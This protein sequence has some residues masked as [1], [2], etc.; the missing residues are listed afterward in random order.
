MEWT[1]KEGNGKEG[2][3]KQ[4]ENG[5]EL[6]NCPYINAN[7]VNSREGSDYRNTDNKIINIKNKYK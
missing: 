6:N 2:R 7:K 3:I 1:R 4:E 5:R